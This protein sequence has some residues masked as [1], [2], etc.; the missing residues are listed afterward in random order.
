MD[1]DFD[2]Q[3]FSDSSLKAWLSELFARNC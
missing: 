3:G 1:R 2:D